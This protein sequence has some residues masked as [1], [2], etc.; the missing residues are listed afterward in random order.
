MFM[1]PFDPP[2]AIQKAMGMQ[3]AVEDANR[4]AIGGAPTILIGREE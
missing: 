4:I 1:M 3:E 2:E